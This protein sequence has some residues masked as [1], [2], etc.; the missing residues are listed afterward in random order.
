MRVCSRFSTRWFLTG[1]PDKPKTGNQTVK[2]SFT[3]PN[4]DK[5]AK[6]VAIA[7]TGNCTAGYGLEYNNCFGI[8]NGNTAPCPRIGRNRMCIYESPEESYA[9]FKI[10]WSRWYKNVPPTRGNAVIWTGNDRPDTW[11]KHVKANL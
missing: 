8:K 9:A 1:T 2:D 3:V 5:L 4:L 7:E 6:A 11:L 10:I